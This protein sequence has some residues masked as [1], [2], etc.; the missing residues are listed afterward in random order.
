GGAGQ[1][2]RGRRAVYEQQ[3]RQNIWRGVG[4]VISLVDADALERRPDCRRAA[5]EQR[6]IETADG[7]PPGKNDEGN[8]EQALTTRNAFVLVAGIEQR[9]RRAAEAGNES[10]ENGRIG[11][12]RLDGAPHR[13]GGIL[14]LASHAQ[15]QTP[16]GMH[17]R[18]L[19]ENRKK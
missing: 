5:E 9:Q 16:P 13:T 8:G 14:T 18:P 10:S 7:I 15:E 12:D 6:G 11:A 4:K 19:K 2:V 17:K 3:E 1:P